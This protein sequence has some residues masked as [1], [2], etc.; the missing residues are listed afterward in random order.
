MKLSNT[1]GLISNLKV[2]FVEDEDFAR[3]ELSRFLKRRVGKLYVG[4]NGL[5]GLEIIKQYNP[6]LV[7]TD[8]KMPNMDGLEMIRSARDI[9]YEGA[10]IIVSAL[11]DSETILNAVDIGIV[12]Y[13]VKPVD[14]EQLVSTMEA[15]A[16][17]I[18]KD[19]LKNTIINNSLL[20]DKEKKQELEQKIRGEI[21]SFIKNYTGKGPR[22]V[23]VFIQG[24][25][26][27]VKAEGV[28]TLLEMNLISN[29]RNN[30]LVDYNRRMFY[31]ENRDVLE[32]AIMSIIDSRVN[33]VEAECDSIT[34][35]DSL[36]LSFA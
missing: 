35:T 13:V 2:L 4:K 9:E 15:I 7:I 20:I 22:N 14:T 18:L 6:D 33:L 30:S 16:P 10:I 17:N 32:Q 31:M 8:L 23:Q 11:S 12:K 3:N 19:K 1:S 34:N 26:I 28:L 27:D 21:A 5:E 25:Y 29:N 24:N 36:K